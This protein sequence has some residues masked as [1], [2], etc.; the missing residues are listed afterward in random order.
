MKVSELG[1]FGLIDILSG[2]VY[3]A[4]DNKAP[5]W[6]KLMIGIGDDAAAWHGDTSVQLATVDSLVQDVHFSLDFTPWEDLG[7]KALAVNLSDIAAMGGLPRYALVS[8]SL[9]GHIEVDNIE[10]MYSGMLEMARQFGVAVIGGNITS[11]PIIAISITVLGYIKKGHHLLTRSSAQPG[12]KIAVTNYLGTSVAGLR[13]LAGNMEFRPETSAQFEEAFLHPFPRVAE[14]QILVEQGIKTAIDISDGLISDLSHICKASNVNAR[15]KLDRIP[16][17]PIVREHFSLEAVEMAL[18]G[19]EDYELLFTGTAD[20]VG[21]VKKAVSCPITI[22]GQI[23]EPGPGSKEKIAI[24]DGEG[25]T[26]K[27]GRSGWDHFISR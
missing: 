4:R 27:L 1:E 20:T 26:V 22:I 18:S 24:V 14:A 10:K 8:L 19:G 17:D 6:Q 2:L 7:W 21:R 12:D 16:V 11:A 23:I 3:G 5:S 13:M 9:P 15:I 25:K